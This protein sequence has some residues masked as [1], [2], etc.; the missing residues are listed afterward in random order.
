VV[1]LVTDPA[2]E[3]LAAVGAFDCAATARRWCA[4]A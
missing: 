3:R 2:A 1:V 4:T